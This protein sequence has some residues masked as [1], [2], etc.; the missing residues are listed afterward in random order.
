MAWYKNKMRIKNGYK[1]SKHYNMIDRPM[2]SPDERNMSSQK[3][4]RCSGHGCNVTCSQPNNNQQKT[5]HF[6][7]RKST[8]HLYFIEYQAL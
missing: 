6:A 2:F 1:Y 7:L 5:E 3:T 8:K 4:Y